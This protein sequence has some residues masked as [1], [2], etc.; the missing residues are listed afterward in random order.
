MIKF[1]PGAPGAALPRLRAEPRQGG[2]PGDD[3]APAA[4]RGRRALRRGVARHPGSGGK[5]AAFCG[6][7]GEKMGVVSHERI[8]VCL[9]MGYTPKYS[10][11]DH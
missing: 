7:N 11:L 4:E 5:M 6:E 10:H 3:A 2:W 8:W 9:K 1:P